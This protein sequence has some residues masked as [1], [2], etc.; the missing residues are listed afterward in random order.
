M[1]A[2]V[3]ADLPTSGRPE[4]TV[5]IAGRALEFKTATWSSGRTDWFS[6]LSPSTATVTFGESVD[7]EPGDL[8]VITTGLGQAWVGYVDSN[9]EHED[10][11]SP[12]TVTVSATD[13]IGRLGQAQLVGFTIPNATLL[14]LAQAM[15]AAAGVSVD[16][17]EAPSVETLPILGAPDDPT[18]TGGMLTYLERAEKSSNALLF[19]MPNGTLRALQRSALPDSGVETIDLVGLDEPRSWETV[20][21]K[22]GIYNQWSLTTDGG[23]LV[24]DETRQDS[25]DRYGLSSYQMSDYLPSIDA[26]HFTE[27]LFDAVA[28]P[29]RILTEASWPISDY[30]QKALVLQPLDWIRRDDET[31]QVMQVSHALGEDGSWSVSIAADQTQ[32]AIVDG[33]QPDP[34]DPTPPPG[35]TT[36]TEVYTV[37]RDAVAA[38]TSAG[39]RY[40]A[41][42]GDV[43]PV[44]RWDGWVYRAFLRWPISWSDF[45]GFIRVKKAE[46]R[47]KT[48]DQQDVGFGSSPQVI[49]QRC[50]QEVIEGAEGADGNYHF[51][52]ALIYPGPNR[53]SSGQQLKAV[54]RSE[55]T[56]VRAAITSIVQGW[57]DHGNDGLA[58]LS[59]NESSTARTTEFQSREGGFDAELTI[60]CYVEA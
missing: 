1:W 28:E 5:A 15:F 33:A 46:V 16:I 50:T 27:G 40:G 51:D 3:A 19:M 54:T 42:K 35:V 39:D 9:T 31:W 18:Y 11:G 59:S 21:G 24:V 52:N 13:I 23:L 41:G 22:S 55:N 30:S 29:R 45:P 38:R 7:A 36:H 14:E 48:S 2:D 58:I 26:S 37:T 8:L 47:L 44:G 25:I 49:F 17:E 20:L 10:I 53:T 57:H 34:E 43:L 56:D 12:P 6:T 4:C 60:T 32:N